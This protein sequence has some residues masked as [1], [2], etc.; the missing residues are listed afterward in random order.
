MEDRKSIGLNEAEERWLADRGQPGAD[1][2][3]RGPT[4]GQGPTGTDGGRQSPACYRINDAAAAAIASALTRSL[5]S[6]GGA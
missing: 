2:D 5:S 3:R 1:R 6:R 4:G